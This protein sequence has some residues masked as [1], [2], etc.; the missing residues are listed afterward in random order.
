MDTHEICLKVLKD[1]HKDSVP[2]VPVKRK[3]APQPPPVMPK[4]RNHA[5]L[6]PSPLAASP[7]QKPSPAPRDL[8]KNTPPSSLHHDDTVE[9][10]ANAIPSRIKVNDSN[11]L[12]TAIDTGNSNSNTAINGQNPDHLF[13]SMQK[14]APPIPSVIR[15]GPPIKAPK[16]AAPALPAR[17]PSTSVPAASAVAQIPT[18]STSDLPINAIFNT[19]RIGKKIVIKLTKGPLGLGFSVTSRDNQTG[20]DCPIYIRNI[21]PKGAAVQDGQLRSGDRLLEVSLSYMSSNTLFLCKTKIFTLL[22]TLENN[23]SILSFLRKKLSLKNGN[24]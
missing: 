16:K 5:P 1:E 17:T 2:E 20:G 12:N 18:Q 23:F 13:T 21:L 3:P 4:P 24:N 14:K 15:P 8:S 11:T 22:E 9:K 7:P 10:P 6:K 19:R